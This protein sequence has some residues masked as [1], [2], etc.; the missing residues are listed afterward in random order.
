MAT[1][2]ILYS[3]GTL[4]GKMVAT[5]IDRLLDTVAEMRRIKL[6]IDAAQT[7]GDYAALAA[8]LGLPANAQGASDAQNLWTIYSNALAAID[9]PA[10]AEAK[11]LDQG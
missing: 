9:A 7:G 10:V 4:V 6:L 2:R 11:R 1:N 5:S 8:E 3:S